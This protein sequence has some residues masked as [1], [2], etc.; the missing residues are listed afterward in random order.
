[1]SVWAAPRAPFRAPGC[2]SRNRPSADAGPQAAWSRAA[3]VYHRAP[4]APGPIARRQAG[5]GAARRPLGRRALMDLAG[6]RQQLFDM[7]ADARIVAH[8]ALGNGRT[9]A[10]AARMRAGNRGRDGR[11][12]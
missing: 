4:S 12:Q 3:R 10:A 7:V 11:A 8:R 9:V 2:A 1:M 6:E 5:A